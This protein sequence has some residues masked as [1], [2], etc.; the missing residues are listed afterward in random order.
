[1][2]KLR[3]LKL[4]CRLLLGE[5]IQG[6]SVGKGHNIDHS[7]CPCPVP[8]CTSGSLSITSNCYPPDLRETILSTGLDPPKKKTKVPNW[9]LNDLNY[10]QS[11]FSTT[12]NDFNQRKRNFEL[13]LANHIV[14]H[15]V[16]EAIGE[17]KSK[18]AKKDCDHAKYEEKSKKSKKL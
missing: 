8:N 14:I 6:F 18:M 13:G 17:E 4:Y 1:M 7:N 10:T 16:N 3:L 12:K 15:M 5:I 11:H 9:K 2:M